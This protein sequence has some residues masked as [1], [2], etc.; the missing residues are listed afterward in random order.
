MLTQLSSSSSSLS[1]SPS[2]GKWSRLPLANIFTEARVQNLIEQG[3]GVIKQQ[4][5]LDEKLRD[6]AQQIADLICERCPGICLDPND[7]MTFCGSF[8]TSSSDANDVTS[9]SSTDVVVHTVELDRGGGAV[10]EGSSS[11]T[12]GVQVVV[13]VIHHASFSS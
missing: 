2:K 5:R 12:G 13:G 3:L 10:Q 9:T 4:G 1:A 8:M 7:V 11:S 6:Y